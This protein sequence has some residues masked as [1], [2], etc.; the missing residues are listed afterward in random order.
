MV[1]EEYRGSQDGGLDDVFEL[2]PNLD[3][4]DRKRI[5]GQE[6]EAR[7]RAREKLTAKGKEIPEY[8]QEGFNWAA[9]IKAAS[10]K[11]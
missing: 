8:L 11:A 1:P 7:F 10:A 6:H 3:D 2:L 9:H 5:K 4:R